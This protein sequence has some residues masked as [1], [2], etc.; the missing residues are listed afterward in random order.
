MQLVEKHQIKTSHNLY[1]LCD[2]LC[3]LGKNLYNAALYEYRQSFI[4][5][6]K[7]TLG[8]VDINKIFNTNNQHD[9]RQ[10]PAKVSNAVLKHLG[11]NITSFWG[12]VSGKRIKRGLYVSKDGK[13]INADVNGAYNIMAK[14]RP[15]LVRSNRIS[16]S[17]SPK[18]IKL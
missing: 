2:T 8:W 15:D 12:L 16:L 14:E 13:K 17:Y 11:D 5:K 10:L 7:K 4:A 3:F 18:R 1:S 9:Y 6:D